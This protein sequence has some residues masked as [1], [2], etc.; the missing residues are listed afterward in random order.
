MAGSGRGGQFKTQT[1]PE[2]GEHFTL[3]P[4][5]RDIGRVA[6]I[7]LF[8]DVRQSG[9]AASAAA[10]APSGSP[11]PSPGSPPSPRRGEEPRLGYGSFTSAA[12]D[13]SRGSARRS[14]TKRPDA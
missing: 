6:R 5:H 2:L 11:G 10:S 9:G 3:R 12:P 13:T 4:A 8:G 7:L 14:R 1:V